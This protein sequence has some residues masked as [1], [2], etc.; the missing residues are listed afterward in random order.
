MQ[1]NGLTTALGAANIALYAAAYTPLKQISVV[2]TWVGAIVGAIPPLMGWASAAGTLEPGS[3]MLAAVLF[4]WQ[5][6]HFMALAYL[7]RED[8]ARAGYRMLSMFDPLGKRTAGC[9]LRHSLV[10]LPM[11][12]LAAGMHITSAPFAAE[13]AALAAAMSFYSLKFWQQPSSAAARK[14]F[15]SSLL[16]LPLLLAALAVHRLP[17]DHS[18]KWAGLQQKL[19]ARLQG[20]QQQGQQQEQQQGQQQQEEEQQQESAGPGWLEAGLRPLYRVGQVWA[21]MLDTS[22]EVIEVSRNMKCPSRAYGEVDD[23]AAAQ[24]QGRQ[25]ADQQV[26]QEQQGHQQGQ[27]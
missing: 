6:P 21:G 22:R 20:Q 16:Y 14:L 5:M 8:Y 11:G 24:E 4:S 12:L 18:I 17:N 19:Q 13:A 23:E 27:Q 1:T 7:N 3:L 15:R 25:Q 2:N 9:A 26:Q 10:L